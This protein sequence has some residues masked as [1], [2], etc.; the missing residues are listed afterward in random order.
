[1]RSSSVLLNIVKIVEP[2][3]HRHRL[4]GVVRAL[5]PR[6]KPS[7]VPAWLRA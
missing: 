3:D 6:S 7:D 5:L 1:M 4:G 2:L